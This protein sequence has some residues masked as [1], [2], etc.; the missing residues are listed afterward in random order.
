MGSMSLTNLSLSSRRSAARTLP[1]LMRM[2]PLL[3]ER[4]ISSLFSILRRSS[5]NSSVW[6]CI[7]RAAPQGSSHLERGSE[8]P[9]R[10]AAANL[11]A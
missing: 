2:P 6:S 7:Q 9:K 5:K 3:P 11:P 1:W 8:D 4:S 10:P